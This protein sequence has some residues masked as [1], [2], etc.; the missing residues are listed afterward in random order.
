LIFK[1]F[2]FDGIFLFGQMISN[3]IRG[4]LQNIVRGTRLEGAADRCTTV[5]YYGPFILP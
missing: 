5:P 3:E 2:F 1:G 4:K